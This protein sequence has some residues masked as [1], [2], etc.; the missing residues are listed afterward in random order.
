MLRGKGQCW[1]SKLL[2]LVRWEAY[3]CKG[4]IVAPALSWNLI[5]FNVRYTLAITPPP[6]RT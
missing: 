6:C 5:K 1:D 2:A 4:I 3:R